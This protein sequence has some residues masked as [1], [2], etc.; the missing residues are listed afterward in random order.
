MP[1]I[2][3]RVCSTCGKSYKGRGEFFCSNHCRVIWTNTHNNVAKREDV[4]EKIRKSRTGK[5]TISNEKHWNWKGIKTTH[6][7]CED[8]GTM[9]NTI[10]YGKRKPKYCKKCFHKHLPPM[11]DETKEK[12]RMAKIGKHCPHTEEWN[13]KIGYAGRQVKHT[14]LIGLKKSEETISKLKQSN[15]AWWSNPYNAEKRFMEMGR[16]PTRPEI[17]VLNFLNQAFPKEWEYVGDGK[18]WIDGKNP[19]F[20]NRNE[21]KLIIEFDGIYW[22]KERRDQDRI[23]NS[24]Y[25]MYGYSILSI[26]ENDLALGYEHIKKKVGDFYDSR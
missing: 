14:W 8:C 16:K 20:I 2:Y 5:P 11:S 21:K 17:V 7:F 22:H 10:P 26:N 1:K 13:R 24:I 3:R 18:F 15:K 23:R 9:L 25:A 12:I 19:D 6:L 4:K